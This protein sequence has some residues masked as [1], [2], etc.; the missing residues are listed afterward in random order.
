MVPRDLP[1]YCLA[2]LGAALVAG[3]P[4]TAQLATKSPFQPAGAATGSAPTAGAP[5]EYRG[6]LETGGAKQF[7]VHDPAR[8][9]GTWVKLNELNAEFGVTAKKYD[10]EERTLTVEYQGKT[11]TL[12]ERQAKVVS[13]GAAAQAMPPPVPSTV[14]TAVTQAVVLNPT[15]ADEQR[16]LDAVAAE[17]QRRR[18]LREQAAQQVGQ[19]TPPP[20]AVPAPVQPAGN[21]PPGV[22]RM[23][24]PLNAPGGARLPVPTQPIAQ[25]R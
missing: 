23:S 9:A 20:A 5:L 13:S 17:V 18:A 6:Y 11:V 3:V 15:P 1:L 25:P 8:K 24:P 19:A 4:A 10:S 16:R 12:A 14:P 2:A 7:R 22:P 21:F